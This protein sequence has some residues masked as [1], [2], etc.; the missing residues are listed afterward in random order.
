MI[1]DDDED[2]ARATARVLESAGHEVRFE[3]SPMSAL[4]S[5]ESRPPDLVL[6]DVMFPEDCSAGYKL[7]A[8]MQRPDSKLA[9]VP[10]LMLTA[11]NSEF[12][13]GFGGT[14][15]D[16][17]KLPVSG[18][19]EKP[20]DLD[21]LQA[22]VASLLGSSQQPHTPTTDSKRARRQTNP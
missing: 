20:V 15:I 14:K 21:V 10:V 16:K 22:K 7:A 3:L 8:R 6:L 19:I 11:I 5:M 1:V 2:F 17:S 13:L 9:K 4:K 18:F 12:A